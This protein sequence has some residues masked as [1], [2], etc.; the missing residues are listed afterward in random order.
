MRSLTILAVLI[1]HFPADISIAE[2][3]RRHQRWHVRALLPRLL[4]TFAWLTC[5]KPICHLWPQNVRAPSLTPWN[6]RDTK[7]SAA[8]LAVRISVVAW[9][10]TAGG[11]ERCHCKSVR[12]GGVEQ[13][14]ESQDVHIFYIINRYATADSTVEI[15]IDLVISFWMHCCHL[16][17]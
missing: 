2:G 4:L 8:G 15:N 11:T 10:I 17:H 1:W 9:Q 12:Y 14:L 7:L 3:Q 6:S 13:M 16:I 5:H